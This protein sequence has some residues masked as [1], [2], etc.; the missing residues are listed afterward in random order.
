M[1]HFDKYIKNRRKGKY[2]ILVLDGYKN[3][4]SKAFQVY[5]KENDIICLYLLLYSNHL[6]QLFDIN[7]FNNLKH[8]YNNQIDRFIKAYINHILKIE[9]FII[10]KIVYEKSI[11]FQNMKSRF[12][13]IDLILFNF[14]II[15]SKLDIR[16]C[17]FISFSFDLNQ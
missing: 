5:C 2:R 12:R 1:K 8:L 17:I 15:L 3:Y 16:I 11:T 4:K 10:F 7:C 14:E 9:F 6:I 13:G